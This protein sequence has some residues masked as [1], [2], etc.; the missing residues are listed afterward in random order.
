M[1]CTYCIYFYSLILN[2]IFLHHKMDTWLKGQWWDE[3][4]VQILTHNKL[5]IFHGLKFCFNE[6]NIFF[7]FYVY[8]EMPNTV[9]PVLY[10]GDQFYWWRTPECQEKTTYLSQVTEKLYHIMLYR[11]HLAWVGFE[12]TISVV[13][14]TD[15]ISS[16]KSNYH[17]IKIVTTT[18]QRKNGLIRQMTS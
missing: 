3:N 6:K 13:I 16:C 2:Y 17:M 10:H 15:C 9:R 4:G 11:V 5:I 12:L 8:E 1:P 18:A 7:P 14:G